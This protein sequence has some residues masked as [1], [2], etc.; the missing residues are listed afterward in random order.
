MFPRQQENTAI[1][2]EIFF[3]QSSPSCYKQDQ[4]TVVVRLRVEVGS[5][6]S[7]V[8]LREVGGDKKGT[9]YVGYK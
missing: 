5:N 2:E 3:M 9:Q 8:A 1:I 4:M 6:T 7:T